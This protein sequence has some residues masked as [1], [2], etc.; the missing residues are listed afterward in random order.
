ME[1]VFWCLLKIYYDS[2]QGT[3]D[4]GYRVLSDLF[5]IFTGVKQGG[6]LSPA[7]FHA[8]IDDLIHEV[9]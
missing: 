9:T 6:I 1:A 3:N 5:D 4:L 8:L 2:S 7:L